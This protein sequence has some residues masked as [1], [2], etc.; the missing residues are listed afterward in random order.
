M[1]LLIQ[2][3]NGASLIVKDIE[4][5]KSTIEIAIFRFDH[6]DIKQALEKAVDRGVSVHA[7]IANTN[8]GE[9]EELRKLEMELLPAG[10]EVSRTADDLLRHHYKFMIID[11]RLLY[12][13]TFNYTHLDIEHSRSFGIVTDDPETVEEAT[14][15]F[16][17]D[18]RRQAYRPKLKTFVVSPINAREQLSHFIKGAE[19][20]LLIYDPEISDR[21]MIRLLRDRAREGVEIRIIGRVSKPSD[22]LDPGRLM[23]MRF[24]T[25]VI[26][27]DRREAFMGSQSLRE[28]DLDKRRELGLIL[29]DRDIVHSLVKVFESDWAGLVPSREDSRAEAAESAKAIKK[30]V[31]VIVKEL[32][33]APIVADALKHVVGDLPKFELRGNELRHNLTDAVKE[34]VE[35]AVSGMVR[36]RKGAPV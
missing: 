28:P 31:K 21:L 14:R 16:H 30:A 17:A 15:L 2:P 32:P 7:L 23:R 12:V 4:E 36:R 18:I 11:R 3:E 35:D 33:L 9:E 6:A 27:R 25:R 5:A 13:L 19:K 1:K 24:H 10:V 8:H 34:A 29:R 20:Q 26:L 22:D